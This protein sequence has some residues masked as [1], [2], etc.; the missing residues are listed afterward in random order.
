MGLRSWRQ[1]GLGSCCGRKESRRSYRGG[2]QATC[3]VPFGV[4]RRHSGL[5]LLEIEKKVLKPT[6]V[7]DTIHS[8]V[9]VLAIK[10]TSKGNRAVVT[11]LNHIV[12]QKGE[13]LIAY[14]AVRMMAGR[15]PA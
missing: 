4:G 12:N 1:R 7:G 15:A 6:F 13:R 2:V 10:P 9:E 8:E 14:K 11:T 3:G 5:A